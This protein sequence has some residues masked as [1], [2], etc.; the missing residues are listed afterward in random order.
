MKSFKR[1]G[2]KIVLMPRHGVPGF[3]VGK[4]D[5]ASDTVESVTVHKSEAEAARDYRERVQALTA[6]NV[7]PL[8]S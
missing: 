5:V 3:I 6:P 4:V 1:H 8:F 2:K 7:L